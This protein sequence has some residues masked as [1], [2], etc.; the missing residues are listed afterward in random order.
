MK[1]KETE[2]NETVTFLEDELLGF[3]ILGFNFSF[4]LLKFCLLFFLLLQQVLNL[5]K[6][7]TEVTV[8]EEEEEEI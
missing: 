2:R 7:L 5:K 4:I 8:S 3:L 1:T 6:E